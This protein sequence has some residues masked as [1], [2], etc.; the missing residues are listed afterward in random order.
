MSLIDIKAVKEQA[1]AEFTKERTDAIKKKLIA[2]MRVVEQARQ[3]LRAEEMKMADLE[4]QVA[5]GTL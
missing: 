1:A 4:A 2:Q 3:V 5:D